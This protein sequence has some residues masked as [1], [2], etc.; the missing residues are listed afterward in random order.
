[1]DKRGFTLTELIAVIVIIGILSGIGIMSVSRLLNSFKV[2]Y[3]DKL[4]K[5]VEAAAREYVSD[6]KNLVYDGNGK[7][8][9]SIINDL[10]N[11]SYISNISVYNKK[12]QNC[13]GS[14]THNMQDN[15]YSVCLICD[16]Q[17]Y[18]NCN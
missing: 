5:S 11:Q 18:G 7:K 3:Y 12:N 13:S 14:V 9:I 15:T 4:E 1:M 2:D 6:H 16:G 10:V 8:Q 17:N